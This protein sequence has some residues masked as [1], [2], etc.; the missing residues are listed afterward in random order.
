MTKNVTSDQLSAPITPAGPS[1]VI[2]PPD[3]E[4]NGLDLTVV[5]MT[6]WRG[7]WI[8]A[9][10]ALIFATIAF[11][12]VSRIEPT[13][14]ASAKVMFDIQQS[15]IIDLQEVLT[16]QAFDSSKLEDEIQVLRS[17]KLIARV[18][19][20]LNLVATPEF[21]PSLR[22]PEPT[23]GDWVR[24]NVTLPPEITDIMTKFGLYSFPDQTEP[25]SVT[26]NSERIRRNAI[27]KVGRSIRLNPLGRSRVIEISYISASPQTAASIV[28]R[29]A[30]QYIVDQLE[31]KLEA[32]RAATNWLSTRVSELQLGLQ[33]AEEAVETARSDITEST[34]QS[35]GV[36]N[37]QLEALNASLAEARAEA[38]L[39]QAKFNLL[40]AALK[41][42]SDIGA[43][44]EFRQSRLIQRYRSQLGELSAQRATLA[45]T[46]RDNH[47]ALVRVDK[48]ITDTNA[49]LKSEARRIVDATSTDL[50][51]ASDQVTSLT[52]EV[53]GLE[54][55]LVVQSREQVKLRQLE[56]EAQARRALYE[57][58]LGRMQETSEQVDLQEANARVLTPAE[59]PLYAEAEAKRA[60]ILASLIL[61]SILG[62]GIIFLLE[63]LN[64]TFRSPTELADHTREKLLGV[65]PQ[66]R[67]AANRKTVI[68]NLLAKPN[69][70]LAEAI[71]NLRTSILFSNVDKPPKVIMFTSS[72]PFEGK[73][74]SSLL[75]A[76]T[77]R[78]MGKST[79]IVD[80]DLRLPV[81]GKTLRLQEE[82]NGLLSY[83]EGSC[84]LD[85]AIK[86]DPT[87]DLHV[88]ASMPA[89]L[90]PNVNAADLLS[91]KSFE[92]M[93]QSL[94]ERY[95]VIILDTPPTLLLSDARIVSRVADAVVYAVRWQKTPRGAV[96]EGLAQL[97]S[98]GAN[99]VGVVMT[100]AN[101]AKMR[102]NRYG[103]YQYYK[104]NYKGYYQ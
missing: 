37:Q 65:I 100:A 45:A 77:S 84:N 13:Y 21:N 44:S 5:L 88:L 14:R 36:T 63:K 52:S 61:G 2:P 64:N 9:I 81:V 68:S 11:L 85:E 22:P 62:A 58:F 104:G 31:A 93:I 27:K 97:R 102:R 90:N 28:N 33:S 6:L 8:I 43:I 59:P 40:E 101:E 91:S 4:D 96:G 54:A 49:N 53:R 60:T 57:S 72:L 18:V 17:T 94:K 55:R 80:C 32:T 47:P 79:I 26:V 98:V 71:R 56:R 42:G 76:I 70:A 89:E 23:M 75:V 83:F 66:S 73:S 46:V 30:E 24:N 74:T 1:G 82:E 95:E 19:D 67:S 99:V 12:F 103:G 34:G 3:N 86:V 7:K 16:D 51:S 29:I 10:C 35:I 50:K 15:N 69:S 20:S 78:R 41:Q 48:Q 38:S 92:T 39:Q 25:L 87:T